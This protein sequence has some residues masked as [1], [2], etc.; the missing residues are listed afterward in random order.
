M[1]DK[2]MDILNFH[3][4]LICALILSRKYKCLGLQKQKCQRVEKYLSLSTKVIWRHVGIV[5]LLLKLTCRK[6][7][8]TDKYKLNFYQSKQKW[9]GI[10]KS[11][12]PKSTITTIR[13][14]LSNQSDLQIKN[15]PNKF[16]H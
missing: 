6:H 7:W 10:L 11:L 3:P 5:L 2:G 15:N 8:Q 13:M 12:I 1:P 4:L 14:K 16:L 9:E